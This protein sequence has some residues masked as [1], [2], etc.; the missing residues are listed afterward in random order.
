MA[1]GEA[2]RSPVVRSLPSLDLEF[3]SDFTFNGEELQSL[4]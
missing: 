1:V 2:C 3:G 4:K